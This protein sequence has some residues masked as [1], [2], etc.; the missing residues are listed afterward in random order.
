VQIV[1]TKKKYNIFFTQ[2]RLKLPIW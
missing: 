1:K 2:F